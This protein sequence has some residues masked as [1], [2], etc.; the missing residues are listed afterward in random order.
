MRATSLL[1]IASA[2]GV[3]CSSMTENR[4]LRHANHIFNTIHSA[5]RQWGSSLH[6]NGM[7]AFIAEVPAHTQLY[8][9]T[10]SKYVV[11]GTEW[12][13][14]EPEHALLFASPHR[15]PPGEP[16]KQPPGLTTTRHASD[17]FFDILYASIHGA[18]SVAQA[19][20]CFLGRPYRGRHFKTS[21]QA[22]QVHMTGSDA[23]TPP[24]PPSENDRFGYLHTYRT[25][26]DLRLLYLDGQSAAKSKKGT[27]DM[28]DIVIL[29]G[30]LPNDDT[31]G[32]PGSKGPM[33]EQERATALCKRASEQWAGRIDGIIRMEGG[34]EIILCSFEDHLDL[35]SIS[36][37]EGVNREMLTADPNILDADASGK[38][39]MEMVNYYRAVAA[40]YNGI[41]GG[42]VRLDFD[43]FAS[44][45]SY[46]SAMYFDNS[47]RPR[48][49][50]GTK[51]LEVAQH[52]IDHLATQI[53]K[54]K[55]RVDWQSIADM[56]VDRYSIRLELMTSG[57]LQSISAIQNEIE[58]AM[59]PFI[60]FGK[61]DDAGELY[62][63]TNQFVVH[64][65]S[66]NIAHQPAEHSLAAAAITNVTATICEALVHA[67]H[68]TR[69]RDIMHRLE[70]L[71][72]WLD[73]ST[74]RRCRDCT[75][76]EVCMLPIWPV[77]SAGDLEHP[78]CYSAATWS[79]LRND[80]WQD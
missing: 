76:E 56:V 79:K 69:L 40:R 32:R 28:Q 24:P 13:A 21:K 58:L 41:G 62:R 19:P 9:G 25:K 8:H 10:S 17:S 78:Q 15:P 75:A 26:H 61:R 14:F 6:H 7:T 38:R 37:G 71:K 74:W 35:L 72:S 51:A 39:T 49:R 34:F 46:P 55:P 50:N 47:N 48:A 63:C 57:T 77:G 44:L 1:V 66:T 16:G 67:S 65:P 73:W 33:F 12:L 31:A 22:K 23:N 30:Q 3:S 59:K 36:Q 42:R 64:T 29:N 53:R 4:S 45:F 2:I 5:M 43:H 80:Y 18:N 68:M 60:D 11:N 27:L 70:E 54:P 52:A 20:K